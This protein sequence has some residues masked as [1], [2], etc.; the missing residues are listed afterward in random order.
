MQTLFINKFEYSLK[1]KY[2]NAIDKK[3]VSVVDVPI[4][5][6]FPCTFLLVE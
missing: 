1:R 6:A 4:S 2:R 5:S 3:T